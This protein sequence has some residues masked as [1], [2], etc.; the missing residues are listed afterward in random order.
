VTLPV[1]EAILYVVMARLDPAI[2]V[3]LR[4]DSRVKPGDDET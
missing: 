4:W 3:E 2:L 1:T